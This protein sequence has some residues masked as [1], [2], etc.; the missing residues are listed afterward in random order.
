MYGYFLPVRTG[1]GGRLLL[2][3]TLLSNMVSCPATVRQMLLDLEPVQPRG[4]GV[5]PPLHAHVAIE[6]QRHGE[7]VTGLFPVSA[8]R[9]QLAQL[10]VSVSLVRSKPERRRDAE[11]R[12]AVR[13]G[14]FE[15]S[16]PPHQGLGQ[17]Q[18]RDR[19]LGLLTDLTSGG[20]GFLGGDRRVH[21]APSG[22]ER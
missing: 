20:E 5:D 13:S 19:L 8:R 16:V 12:L 22:E 3:A 7:V 4:R 18:E 14:R 2:R 1:A 17:D 9:E 11:R 15:R 10:T 21:G 6:G